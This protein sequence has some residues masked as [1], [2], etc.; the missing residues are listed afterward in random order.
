MAPPLPSNPAAPLPAHS[1]RWDPLATWPAHYRQLGV[2][3]GLVVLLLQGA[4]FLSSFWPAPL[5]DEQGQEQASDYFQD[6]TSGRNVLL[7]KEAYPVLR[8]WLDEHLGASPHRV[9]YVERNAHPPSSILMVLPFCLLDYRPSYLLWDASQFVCFLLGFWLLGRE[10]S[11]RW[12]WSLVLMVA[13][14]LMFCGPLRQQVMQGQ[15]NGVLVLLV[16][17]AWRAS[18][19]GRDVWAGVWLGLA[20]AIKLYPGFLFVHFLLLRRWRLLGA[21]TATFLALTALTWAVLGT[22]ALRVYVVEVMPVVSQFRAGWPNASLP[23]FWSKLFDAGQGKDA[24][25]LVL[26]RY[27]ALLC[28]VGMGLSVSALLGLWAWALLS[29][30]AAPAPQHL[31]ARQ[32]R[33]DL[34]FSLS[35]LTMSLVSPITWDHYLLVLL[36]SLLIM[37]RE[38]PWSD[39]RAWLLTV[40]AGLCFLT[41]P[42]LWHWAGL[43]MNGVAVPWQT[44]TVL[45]FQLY[46]LLLWFVLNLRLL[47]AEEPT[48]KP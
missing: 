24:A 40:I 27:D 42:T 14:V 17:A 34:L 21:G 43:P 35:L 48:L 22:E 3:L 37:S 2:F 39:P 7:G 8:H 13:G 47:R 33:E 32:R 20:T 23:G 16:A 15:F 28:R 10:L 36:V 19:Q 18:R 6:W 11:L 29:R 12:S 45:S 26:L 5:K 4:P 38:L 1:P 25:G 30:P 31:Q 41:P 46:A 44:L 9:L